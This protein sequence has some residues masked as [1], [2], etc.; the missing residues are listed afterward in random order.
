MYECPNC[1]G[2][3]KFDIPSQMLACSFCGTKQ[4]PYEAEKETDAVEKE[5]FETTVFTCPQCAGELFSTDNEATTFCSFCGA[6]T[7]LSGRIRKEKR[8]KYIIP[9]KKTKEDCKKAY[10]T[11]MKYAF[12]APK[13]LKDEKYIDGFRG[14]YMPTGAT[15]WF[16]IIISVCMGKNPIGRG[17]ILSLTTIIWKAI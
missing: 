15:R 1:G 13:E 2:N 9:F 4:N 11:K 7:V 8:P 16:R 12:F 14:I 3:L 17:I 6:S 5:Y 10:A